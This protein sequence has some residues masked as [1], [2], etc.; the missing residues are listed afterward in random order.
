VEIEL[1]NSSIRFRCDQGTR[2]SCSGVSL[3]DNL[4]AVLRATSVR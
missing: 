2:Q 1:V 4:R 3:D